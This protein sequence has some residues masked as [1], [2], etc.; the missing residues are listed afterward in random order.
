MC[1]KR[2]VYDATIFGTVG[3]C[4]LT[5]FK[6]MRAVVVMAEAGKAEEEMAEEAME[7]EEMEEEAMVE[8]EMVE[9]EME[10]ERVVVAK[11]EAGAKTA[12]TMDNKYSN[13]NHIVD[14]CLD[15]LYYYRGRYT[16]V[17][18]NPHI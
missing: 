10:E 1:F 13:S 17:L 15:I 9:E 7:K 6:P 5:L 14:I 12:V 3:L 11:T 8:E 16:E 18:P 2:V 4:F